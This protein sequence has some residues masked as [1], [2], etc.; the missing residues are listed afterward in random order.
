MLALTAA[1]GPLDDRPAAHHRFLKQVVHRSHGGPY[2][3]AERVE[4][5][6]S[7]D[8]Q[9]ERIGQHLVD[10]CLRDLGNGIDRLAAAR[11]E[12]FDQ[13]VGVCLERLSHLCQGARRQCRADDRA[14]PGV[15]W[16]VVR[17]QQLGAHGLR[18]M[19]WAGC[20]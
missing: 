14:D 5:L 20:R 2:H 17:Q 18:V 3:V 6:P 7:C 12:G 10:E 4:M 16:R 9:T 8:G 15:L 11:P 13:R 1:F 19:P